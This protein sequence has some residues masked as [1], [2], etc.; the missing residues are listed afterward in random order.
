MSSSLLCWFQKDGLCNTRIPCTMLVCL[1]YY[2]SPLIPMRKSVALAFGMERTYV[3]SFSWLRYQNIDIIID[4]HA[5]AI[6]TGCEKECSVVLMVVQHNHTLEGCLRCY[7]MSHQLA[8]LAPPGF[9]TEISNHE[10]TK[11][12]PAFF[13]V[14][15]WFS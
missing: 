7:A 4:A 9:Q 13:F 12:S 1:C 14:F 8:L 5:S 2:Y 3:L 6:V 10:K 15:L 11:V